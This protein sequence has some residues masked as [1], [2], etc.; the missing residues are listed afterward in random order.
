MKTADAA[1][2]GF[3]L[4][5]GSER[6]LSRHTLSNYRR[7]LT[8]LQEYL[9][10]STLFPDGKVNW[11]KVETKQIRNFVGWV[12]REGL[13]G[14]SI[15]RLLSAI[16]SFYKYLHR[17]GL[18]HQNPALG[19]QAPKSP[20]KLPQTL[21]VDQLNQLLESEATDDPLECRDQ[22]MMELIYSSG[23]RLSELVS[24]DLH[25]IDWQDAS[26]RVVG[27]GSK[28]RLL[29][30]GGKAMQAIDCWL[31]LRDSL[32]RPEEMALFVSKRGT[33]ISTRSVQLRIDRR[34]KMQHTQGKVY[35]HR[36]RHSFAS[37]ML[38]S[39][40]DLRAVQELLGHSDISTT[41]IYTHLDF[42]HLMDVYEKA[43][44]RAHKQTE[45]NDD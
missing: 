26:L 30:I 13:S 19:V 28:E 18:V 31:N 41:Q 1:L 25:S 11:A 5:L 20:R 15:Q 6:Q 32:A 10:H 9:Q 2:D 37:H 35:P 14:K 40:G 21:D 23:L 16:R 24:L 7:D 22:A 8:R 45:N 12:H 34:G 36:L 39:S 17:E 27:K 4:Y 3:Y 38:E 42:R 29:P 43:H 33:R 44:P